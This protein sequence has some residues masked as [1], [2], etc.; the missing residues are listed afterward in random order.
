VF[1]LNGL[2]SEKDDI[3]IMTDTPH[4]DITLFRD[5]YI[6]TSVIRRTDSFWHLIHA[7]AAL[8]EGLDL[9]WNIEV[10]IVVDFDF[11]G[12]LNFHL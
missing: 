2:E 11:S 12:A 10:S 8:E 4:L 3:N 7:L 9:L 1:Q 5:A 6:E